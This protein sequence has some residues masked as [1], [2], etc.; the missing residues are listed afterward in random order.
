MRKSGDIIAQIVQIC[1]IHEVR[2]S[3]KFGPQKIGVV[4]VY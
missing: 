3:V 4:G 2:A 1:L